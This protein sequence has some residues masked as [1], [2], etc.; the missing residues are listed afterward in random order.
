MDQNSKHTSPM[1][2]PSDNSQKVRFTFRVNVESFLFGTA[3]IAFKKSGKSN[4]NRLG[5]KIQLPVPM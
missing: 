1:T 3:R 4:A 2:S 5:N